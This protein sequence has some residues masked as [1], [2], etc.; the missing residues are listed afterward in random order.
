MALTASPDDQA[1]LLTVQ[2]IDTKLQQL[3]HRAKNLP[4]IAEL[5]RLAADAE[6]LRQQRGSE[7]GNLEDARTELARIESDVT[8][9]AARIT[10]DRERL[11]TSSSVKDVAGLEHE[12]EGLER[13]RG[14]LEDIELQ[15]MER[16]EQLE[17]SLELTTAEH[18]DVLSRVTTVTSE[19]DAALAALESEQQHAQANRSTLVQRL[20]ADLMALYERQRSRYGFGASHLQGGVSGASG[21]R[22]L[23]NELAEVR[24]AAPDAVLICP[25]SQA[26]LV[27]TGESGL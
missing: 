22:L 24:A 10:R 27:R 23:E 6:T 14:E 20:P 3:G 15:V 2:A 18:A 1:Q 26:I 16:V 21:V 5:A 25:D 17:K 12:I 19:R 11:A 4:E 9:V 13:R 7:A 8:V